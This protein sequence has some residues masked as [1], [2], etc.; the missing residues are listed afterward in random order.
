MAGELWRE[1]VLIGK[2]TVEGVAVAATRIVYVNEV[3]FE[4]SRE[5][6]PQSF[7]TGTRDRVRARTQGSTE[8]GGSIQLPASADELMEWLEITFG[9][10]STTTPSGGATLTRQHRYRM[11]NTIPTA[12]LERNDGARIMRLLGARGSQMTIE[13]DVTGDNLFTFDLFATDRDDAQDALTT[14]LTDR[15]PSVLQGWQT[16]VYL[17]DLGDTPGT[18]QVNDLLHSW[19]V[20]LNNNPEREYVA[21]NSQAAFG[22]NLGEP[23]ISASLNVRAASAAIAG[24]LVKWAA[25]TPV[26]LRLEFLGPV[27]GIETGFRRSVW[28]DLPGYYA[29]P[30]FNSDNAQA[31]AYEFPLDYVYDP[32]LGSSIDVTLRNARLASF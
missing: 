26:M 12:T 3:S 6:M 22:V 4:K 28:V 32:T 16:N 2:E 25:N 19:S 30:D 20:T 8:A 17:D 31:R 29:S 21:R 23:E 7:A 9:A 14:G 1:R 10:P 15:V 13:G 18:T 11:A 24:E 5:S 27:D